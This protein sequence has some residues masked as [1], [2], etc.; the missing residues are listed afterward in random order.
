MVLIYYIMHLNNVYGELK[1]AYK[2]KAIFKDNFD[3]VYDFTKK[4]QKLNI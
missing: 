4:N 1:T 3:N 2:K